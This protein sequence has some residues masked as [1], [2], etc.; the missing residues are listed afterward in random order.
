[1]GLFVKEKESLI[2]SKV[3]KV[4]FIIAVVKIAFFISI[5][6]VFFP[7]KIKL[8]KSVA[9]LSPTFYKNNSEAK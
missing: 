1:M 7:K 3:V 8:D 6:V 9:I 4:I 5:K 2:F